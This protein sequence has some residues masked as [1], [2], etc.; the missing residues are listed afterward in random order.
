M[1]R[2]DSDIMEIFIAAANGNLDKLAAPKWNINPVVNV[3]LAAKGYPGSYKKNTEIKGVDAA[4]LLDGVQVFHAGTTRNDEGSLRA[5]GG[6]VLNITAEGKT[7]SQAVSRAYAAID[8][9]ID[10]PDGFC[11][12]DIAKQAL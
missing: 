7:I 2:L 11:R 12:R 4:N 8:E 6:R 1:R 10:W 5:S 3:V 9:A